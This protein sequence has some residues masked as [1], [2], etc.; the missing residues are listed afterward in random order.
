MNSLCGKVF[1]LYAQM[2]LKM[3]R[4]PFRSILPT[5]DVLGT[6]R[7]RASRPRP[8]ARPE[9]AR[10]CTTSQHLRQRQRVCQ[11][12]LLRGWW[13][14]TTAARFSSL[15]KRVLITRLQVLCWRLWLPL[16]RNLLGLGRRNGGGTCDPEGPP[17]RHRPRALPHLNQSRITLS[18]RSVALG[19]MDSRL[20][21]LAANV[22]CPDSAAETGL[23]RGMGFR[24][25]V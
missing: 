2:G 25:A 18:S 14:Q 4:E 24:E 1:Y 11:D 20:A 22:L 15:F 5:R 23:V 13:T 19:E 17:S 7:S 3:D 21:A 9:L 12:T 8:V 10:A 16:S 6:Y